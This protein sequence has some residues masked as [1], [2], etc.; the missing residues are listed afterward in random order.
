MTSLKIE[1][2]SCGFVINLSVKKDSKNTVILKL[3]TECK[4]LKQINQELET[5]QIIEALKGLTDNP[6]FKAASKHLKHP[7]CPVPFAI[8]KAIETELGL[9]LSKDVKIKFN[10]NQNEL[11]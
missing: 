3:D 7:S 5:I 4:M 9:A 11:R 8:L 1:A 10:R 2:G 6:V